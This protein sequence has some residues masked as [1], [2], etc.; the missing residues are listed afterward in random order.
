[1][2]LSW[3]TAGVD[4]AVI[5][6]MRVVLVR[7]TEPNNTF[8]SDSAWPSRALNGGASKHRKKERCH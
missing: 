2:I 5:D 4:P 6:R 7:P 1:M 8:P 3:C